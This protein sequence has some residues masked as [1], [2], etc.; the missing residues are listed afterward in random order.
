LDTGSKGGGALVEVFG[1]REP[2]L[3]RHLSHT[4]GASL[5]TRRGGTLSAHNFVQNAG[6]RMQIIANYS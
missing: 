6:A 3:G 1:S 5:V 4:S 2:S